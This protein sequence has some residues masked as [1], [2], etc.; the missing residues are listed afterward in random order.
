MPWPTS[1]KATA[2]DRRVALIGLKADMEKLSCLVNEATYK[3]E[4]L[5][6]YWEEIIEETALLKRRLITRPERDWD[7]TRQKDTRN[8]Q[9]TQAVRERDGETCRYCGDTVTWTDRKSSAA[10][11]YSHVNVGQGAKTPEDMVV[12]CKSCNKQ[13]SQDHAEGKTP[14]APNPLPESAKDSSNGQ[15]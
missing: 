12:S 10:A 13:R 6:E 2:Q 8:R 4:Y 1:R 9:L 14:K 5:N 11:T 15:K 3:E 7:Q